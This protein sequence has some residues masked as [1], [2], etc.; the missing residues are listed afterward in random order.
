MNWDYWFY[1][2]GK[3]LFWKNVVKRSRAKMGDIVSNKNAYGYIRVKLNQQSY[4]AHRIIWEM[5]YGPIPEGMQIDHINHDRTD[6]RL[7]NL[8]LVTA[9]DNMKNQK[10]R[11]DNTSG[12]TGVRFDASR[13]RWIAQIQVE[14][15]SINLGRFLSLDMAIDARRE[16]ELKNSFHEN[17]GA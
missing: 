13:G 8:R 4:F 11:S 7:C 12:I 14:G 16:A 17:H 3:N 10:K 6:N 15:K 2:D 1:Y 5:H 9:S